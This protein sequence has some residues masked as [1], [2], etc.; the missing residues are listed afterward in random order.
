MKWEWG[1]FKKKSLRGPRRY[2]PG[3]EVPLYGI[4]YNGT[5]SS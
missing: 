3:D 1:I 4:L 5:I 2:L